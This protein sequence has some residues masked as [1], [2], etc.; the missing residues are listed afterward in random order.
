MRRP[1]NKAFA[2]K[3]CPD[4]QWA[5]SESTGKLVCRHKTD[6]MCKHPSH[7]LCELS[8]F[9]QRSE[10][11]EARGGVS[12]ISASRI[13]ILDT[14]M[15]K[16]SFIYDARLQSPKGKPIYF[17]VGT[18]FSNCR[19]KIDMKLPWEVPDTLPRTS[20][21]KLMASLRFYQD[22]PPYEP[23]TVGCE[24]ETVFEH[25][26]E[27][28]LGYLDAMTHDRERI[29]EWKYAVQPYDELRASRQAA[30]YFYRFP[31]AK[32]FELIIF[33]KPTHK[34]LKA[35]RPSKKNP[36][37]QPETLSEFEERIYQELI[38]KGPARVYR[39]VIIKR[40]DVAVVNT[41]D[42]MNA[43]FRMLEVAR[44]AD[45][46]PSIGKICSEC[47]FEAYCFTNIGKSTSEIVELVRKEHR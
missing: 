41:L 8:L 9:K 33:A 28:Y 26:G 3:L 42:Q 25:D 21:H 37:P 10:A 44:Q 7:F 43:K 11:K 18:A 19:A 46:P 27:H 39:R 1:M 32:V 31:K 5:R 2:E 24:I 17:A 36:D 15:R 35:K 6:D 47:D 40:D 22:Y 29:I 13:G 45:Y 38:K 23:G 12:A 20:Y 4:I 14:C 30:V 16:Y 34:P